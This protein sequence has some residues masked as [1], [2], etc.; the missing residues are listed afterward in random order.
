MR[1]NVHCTGK[2][3]KK[4]SRKDNMDLSSQ[5]TLWKRVKDLVLLSGQLLYKIY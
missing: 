5:I 2:G 4:G 1:K 3:L